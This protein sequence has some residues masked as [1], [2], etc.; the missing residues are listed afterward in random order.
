VPSH[1]KIII[2]GHCDVAA[3]DQPKSK[4]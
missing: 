2:D 4:R 3:T 1:G